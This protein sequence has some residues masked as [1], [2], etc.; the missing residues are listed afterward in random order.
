MRETIPQPANFSNL[1]RVNN[2]HPCPICGK[3]DWCSF[4][5]D[6]K[7]ALCSRT[8][9]GAIKQARNGSWI[10]RLDEHQKKDQSLSARSIQTKQINSK[11]EKPQC[12]RAIASHLHKVYSA[13]LE[14]LELYS[15]HKDDLLQRGLSRS[16]IK[17]NC[18]KSTPS[19]FD[20]SQLAFELGKKFDLRGVPGFFEDY[21]TW[22][23][24]KHHSGFFVPIRNSHNQIYGLQ[25]RLDQPI[26]GKQKYVWLSSANYYKGTSSSTP[27]H[28]SKPELI[29]SAKE[30]LITEGALKGDVVSYFTDQPV[31]SAAGVNNFG[32]SFAPNLRKRFP[33]LRKTILC[34]DAD[35]YENEPV[36][37]ALFRLGQDLT[38]SY[39]DVSVRDWPGEYKGF[40]DFL[41]AQTSYFNLNEV[42]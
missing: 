6:G 10:H 28:F 33:S 22:R 16:F 42:A 31:I 37:N 25:I 12:K 32:E 2:S 15:Q 5:S 41:L 17:E 13:M 27:I 14:W 1:K 18:Y 35:A 29:N 19:L 36:R 3:T 30:T 38:R 4:T 39:F 11:K 23:M 26:N 21:G 9:G 20:A 7:L 24:V 8:P 34:F 40:D